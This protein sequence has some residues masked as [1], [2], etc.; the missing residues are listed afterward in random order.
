VKRGFSWPG[1][2]FG[3]IWALSRQLWWQGGLLVLFSVLWGA[4]TLGGAVGSAVFRVFLYLL[5]SVFVGFKGNSWRARNLEAR[6]Y[7]LLGAINARDP[8]DALAKVAAVGGTI[9]AE[10]KAGPRRPF[11]LFSVPAGLQGLLAIIA[12]TWKAAFR[13][14]LF[15]VIMTLLLGAV[16]GLPLLLKHDGTAEGFAQILITYTLGTVTV[17]LGLCTLWLA[18]GTLARDVEECQIQMVVVKPIARWQVWLGKWLGLLSLNAVLLGI[19]GLSV[20]SLLEWR[21]RGLSEE[22]LFKLRTQVLVARASARETGVDQKIEQETNRRLQEKIDKNALGGAD[23]RTVRKRLEDQVRAE[24]QSVSP[25]KLRVW[26]IH[27]GVPKARLK[28]EPLYLRVKFNTA[29]VSDTRTYIANWGIGDPAGTNFWRTTPMSLSADAFH[30]FAVPSEFMDDQG[31]LVVVFLNANQTAL[32]FPL[33]DGMEV[34]YREGGFALNLVRGLGIILCWM[35]LFAALGLAAASFL[36]FPVA[37]FCSLAILSIG[38]SSGTLSNVVSEG[39]F[40]GMDE[41]TM[42]MRSTFLDDL[43]VPTFGAMLKVINLVEGFSPVDS[44]STGRSVSW[45]ELGL[46]AAQIVLLLGGALAVFGI[47]VFHRRELAT[48]QATH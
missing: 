20:Y 10:L 28:D 34:L 48:T 27:L 7:L 43:M 33:D 36:S 16:V 9:P 5:Y 2:F 8:Q 31:N 38:L 37:A 14:R 45:S 39:T 15:W 25:D 40:L 11:G 18:C 46:A 23:V 32:L 6:G 13:Y 17:L 44:L 26:A 22:E 29:Q 24:A 35:A 47:Y 19:V 21:A 41:E 3:C 4:V 42:K 1:F 12:L 30:E